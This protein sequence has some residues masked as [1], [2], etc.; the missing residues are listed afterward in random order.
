MRL[1]DQLKIDY[2]G[3]RVTE[4]KSRNI[5]IKQ[6]NVGVTYFLFVRHVLCMLQLRII[7]SDPFKRVCMEMG[8]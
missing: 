2:H 3:S 8:M 4:L 7:D 1:I 6:V 5:H